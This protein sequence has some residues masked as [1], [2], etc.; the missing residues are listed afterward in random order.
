VPGLL[1]RMGTAN[2]RP[3]SFLRDFLVKFRRYFRGGEGGE[4]ALTVLVFLTEFILTVLTFL[5]GLALTVL[6]SLT[7]LILTVLICPTELALT[8]LGAWKVRQMEH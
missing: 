1:R 8:V 3:L 7:E 4:L 2:G 6:I 5:T